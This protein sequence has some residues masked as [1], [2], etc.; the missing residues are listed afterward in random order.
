[1]LGGISDQLSLPLQL[2]TALLSSSEL[3]GLSQIANTQHWLAG[4]L[5]DS[6]KHLKLSYIASQRKSSLYSKAALTEWP[7]W[8]LPSSVALLRSSCQVVKRCR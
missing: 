3:M 6:T 1:M 4:S 2:P 5:L 7:W 8:A